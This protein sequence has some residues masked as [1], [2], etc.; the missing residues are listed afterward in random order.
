MRNMLYRDIIVG[1]YVVFPREFYV[2]HPEEQLVVNL[3]VFLCMTGLFHSQSKEFA[4]Y[5]HPRS[6]LDGS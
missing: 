4:K 2:P 3:A 6:A 1:V 5:I